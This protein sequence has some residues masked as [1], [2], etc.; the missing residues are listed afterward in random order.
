M[1]FKTLNTQPS[2]IFSTNQ[3]EFCN[4]ILELS[5]EGSKYPSQIFDENPHL[6][7][8]CKGF[9]TE[10]LKL[11]GKKPKIKIK[12]DFFPYNKNYTPNPSSLI[13]GLILLKLDNDFEYL[14]ID[15]YVS[16]KEDKYFIYNDTAKDNKPVNIGEVLV[17]DSNLEFTPRGAITSV[18]FEV[19]P[20]DSSQEDY[21]S[22]T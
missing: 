6:L 8:K 11:N 13:T 17:F 20:K 10:F 3:E 4:E 1:K 18:V 14:S 2:L 7:S 21:I 15:F 19:T 16:S 12:L 5:Q 22:W 9:V